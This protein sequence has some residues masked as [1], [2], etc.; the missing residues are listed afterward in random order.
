MIYFSGQPKK[1]DKDKLVHMLDEFTDYYGDFYITRNNLRLFI[2]ENTHLLYECLKKGDKIVYHDHEGIIL[3]TGFS[4]KSPR[5]YVKILTESVESADR[6]LKVLIWNID[7]DLWAKIK[8]NNPVKE[9][10]RKNGFKFAGD[11]GKEILLKRKQ[12]PK[13]YQIDKG[14]DNG[15][16]NARKN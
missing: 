16:N 2:K 6:L 14:D 7:C 8:K 15:D 11:R 3:V 10:L 1:K 9:A 4:D 13:K 12:M 5:K